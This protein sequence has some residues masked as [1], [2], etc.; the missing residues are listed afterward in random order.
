[1]TCRLLPLVPDSIRVIDVVHAP[2][3]IIVHGCV[4]AAKPV[5][6]DCR[7]LSNAN[8]GRYARTLCDLPWQGKPVCLCV[9]VR[10]FVCRNPDCRRRTFSE[11]LGVA[12]RPSARRSE[13]LREIQRHLGLALGG[14]PGERLSRRLGMATSAD[15]LVRLVRSGDVP[16]CVSPRVVGID[17]WAWRRGRRYGTMIV[18]LEIN[19]IVDL[20]PDRDAGTLANWLKAHPA[21]EIIARD[22]AEVFADG[23]R[24]GAPDVCQVVDR[25]HLLVPGQGFETGFWA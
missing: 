7:E 14:E 23:I 5:C 20:L 24:A 1:M 13:R 8:H 18:D 15:T 9:Q 19:E 21:V 3:R 4:R 17:E 6:P 12:A 11:R 25:W 16:P 10:R 22:R 2:D